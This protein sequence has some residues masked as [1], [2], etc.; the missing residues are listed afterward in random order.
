[1]DTLQSI[2]ELRIE[3][4]K[5]TYNKKSKVLAIELP[6]FTF[7]GNYAKT[8]RI[9]TVLN[10]INKVLE[11]KGAKIDREDVYFFDGSN[12]QK[13]HGN[14]KLKTLLKM[15]VESPKMP[16][17]S[18][19]G[20]PAEK[21]EESKKAKPQL[22]KV[23]K[24]KAKKAMTAPRP[25]RSSREDFRSFD[26][27]DDGLFDMKKKEDTGTKKGESY[28]AK[29]SVEEELL[30]ESSAE[31]ERDRA[32]KAPPP[33]SGGGTPKASYSPAPPPP[34][35]APGGP[36][37][38]PLS[39]TIAD[40]TTMRRLEEQPAPSQTE[41][42]IN[43]GLQYYS[44]MMERRSYLFY[45]YFSHQELKIMDEEGKTVYTTT[46]KIV[47]K[48]KE[49]PILDLKIEGEDFEVHPLAGRVEVKKDAVNPPVMIF[50]V[51]PTKSERLKKMKESERRFLNVYIHFEGELLS[52]TILSIIVQ[53]K[54]FKLKLGPLSVNLNKGTAI[55]ISIASIVV[56]VLLLT[57][58]IF[59]LDPTSMTG[60]DYLTGLVPQ[61]GSI[62]FVVIYMYTLVKGI[63]PIKQ[64]F[65]G[66]LNFDKGSG[67]EK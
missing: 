5:I 18:D 26:T 3:I 30:E 11:E 19:L 21:K 22:K 66:L 34:P 65:S 38:A 67:F 8:T 40:S 56:S 28:F 16:T 55:V 35:S 37:G 64:Q 1:M 57:Y 44:V 48:K 14:T 6:G 58:S 62:L 29:E 23:A 46:I 61:I 25:T 33:P 50:S 60:V 51:M 63:Y 7:I 9:S 47:T 2:S 24:E 10:D 13:L 31:I 4:N 27:E 41:Y 36:P 52:H 20:P 12:Q 49:P 15:K 43:M 54:H 45:V 39:P 53:P 59:T 17:T 32:P 42:N